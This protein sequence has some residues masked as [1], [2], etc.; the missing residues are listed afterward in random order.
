M[1]IKYSDQ[2][3]LYLEHPLEDDIMEFVNKA[4]EQFLTEDRTI[5]WLRSFMG[6]AT[7]YAECQ[8]SYGSLTVDSARL[9]MQRISGINGFWP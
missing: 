5:K 8:F 2:G 6:K 1:G 4:Y 3:D 9:I 7:G